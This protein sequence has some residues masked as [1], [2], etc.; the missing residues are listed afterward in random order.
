GKVRA[1]EDVLNALH[2]ELSE[3][4]GVIVDQARPLIKICHDYP[5]QSVT[6]DVWRVDAWHGTVFGREGQQVDWVARKELCK[7]AFPIANLP[8]ITAVNLPPLYLISPEPDRG[9]DDF[10]SKLDTCLRAGVR[11]FQLRSQCLREDQYR[12]LVRLVR[13]VCDVHG[14]VLLLNASP[15]DVLGCGADGV[16]LSSARL[17][18]LK[19]RP[20]GTD[21]WVGASC[22]NVTEILHAGRIGVDFIVLSPVFATPTH[23]E[24]K[25]LGWEGFRQLAEHARMPVYALGGMQAEHLETAWRVGAQ[26]VGM[27]S[28]IWSAPDPKRV[29]IECIAR[30]GAW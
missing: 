8:I 7:R 30:T 12:T 10:L 13:R 20:L 22:H 26:G 24:A 6:L 1:D 14:A 15:S 25:P 5:E 19:E 9:W 29:I 27:V 4:V 21:Q 11:L 17:L 3:E 16:H 2:R 23:P 28:A 18:Q